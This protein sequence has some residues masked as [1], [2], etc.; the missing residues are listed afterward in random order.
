MLAWARR[1]HH[2]TVSELCSPS[3]LLAVSNL[4]LIILSFSREHSQQ[5]HTLTQKRERV[6]VLTQVV[7][8]QLPI[9]FV[10]VHVNNNRVILCHSCARYQSFWDLSGKPDTPLHL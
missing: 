9:T 1:V 10:F 5:S 3:I 7:I 8:A 6:R 4:F 2:D